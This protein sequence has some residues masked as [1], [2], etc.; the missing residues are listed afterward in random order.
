MPVRIAT[1][2]DLA[3]IRALLTTHAQT[4]GGL[5]A[6]GGRDDLGSALA[7]EHPTVFATI[8]TLPDEPAVIAGMALWYRTFSSW[9]LTSGIWLE[10]LFV[11]DSYRNRGLGLEL[12]NDLR[13]RTSGRVDWE[14]SKGNAGAERFYRKLGAAPR[15]GWTQYRWP[16]SD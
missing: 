2:D 5:V 15:S 10:D 11:D 4:E 14:V 7:G 16:A 9:A 3:M 6:V 13:G 12:M 1:I 8:V